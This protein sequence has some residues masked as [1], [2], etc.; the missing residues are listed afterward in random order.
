MSAKRRSSMDGGV[1]NARNVSSK[2]M[3]Y[4]QQELDRRAAR[5]IAAAGRASA[6]YEAQKRYTESIPQRP[7]KGGLGM[8]FKTSKALDK[9]QDTNIIPPSSKGSSVLDSDNLSAAKIDMSKQRAK[10]VREQRARTN[11]APKPP[12][13]GTKTSKDVP[14]QKKVTRKVTKTSLKDRY[15]K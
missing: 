4:S 12:K 5:Q 14:G 10:M 8:S 9:R 2:K 7:N 11:T 1:D 13:P 6:E 15:N 3:Q